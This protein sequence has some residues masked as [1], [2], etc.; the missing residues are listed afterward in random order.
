MLRKKSLMWL[1]LILLVLAVSVAPFAGASAASAPKEIVI[2]AINSLTGMNAMTGAEQKWAYEQSVADINEKGGVFVKEYNKKLPIKLIFAD[3]KSMDDGGSAAMER[4]IKLDKIDFAL[5]SNVTRINLGAAVVCEKY[6]VY[7]GIVTS[8]LDLVEKQHF[9]WTSDMFT[10]AFE[11]G[12]APFLVWEGLPKEQRPK[13]PAL[14]VTDNQDGQGLGDGI[15]GFAKQYG[16]TFA[17][18]EPYP[19]GTKDFSSYILK[20]KAS[21][22]DAL[23]WLGSPTDGITLLRQMKEQNVRFPYTHGWRGLWPTEFIKAMGKDA[24]YIIH[25][26][27]W[28][29]TLPFP[30]AK[31]LGEKF[32]KQ[33]GR[34]SVSIGLS[35]ANP[36]ILAMAIERAG[37]LE[38]AK[39]RDA[40]FGGEFKGTMMGDVKY[41]AQG[42]CYKPLLGLQW[43]NGQRMPVF[44]SMPKVWTIKMAPTSW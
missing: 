3:D 35:Y 17:V 15:R 37:S 33:F 20:W 40:I 4:L 34:D 39:V 36:Q 26:G 28:A 1:G 43:W 30:G 9:K 31:E 24:D 12:H 10:S 18:D 44:P 22:V 23:L 16:Y 7:F 19:Q 42:L 27:F 14:M 11:A 2:G 29:E 13:K 21:G 5:S 6:K 32:R 38:S 25:D 41:N 8:W